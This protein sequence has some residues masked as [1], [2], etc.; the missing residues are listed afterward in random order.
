MIGK[1]EVMSKHRIFRVGKRNYTGQ[2]RRTAQL[3]REGREKEVERKEE[4]LC[5]HPHPHPPQED[6]LQRGQG[7][8][9]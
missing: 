6:E 9:R 3:W 7:S 8:Q 2:L 4:L 1:D 5:P